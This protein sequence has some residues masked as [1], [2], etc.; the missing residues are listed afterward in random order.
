MVGKATPIML[1]LDDLH[2]ADTPTVSLLRHLVRRAE[3]MRVLV[4]ATYRDSEVTVGHPLHDLL[5]LPLLPA[6]ER[7]T[8][9]GLGDRELVAMLEQ[10]AGHAMDETG[11]G[12]ADALRRDTGGNPFF[13]AELLR[14]LVETGVLYRDDTDRWQLRGTI[15]T[16]GLPDSAREVIGHRVAHL[17]AGTQPVL[18][19]AA[20]IGQEFELTVLARVVDQDDDQVLDHL[21]RSE[22][23]ALVR[24]L[25]GDEFN[26]R[27][28]LVQHALYQD[29]GSARRSR[30]HLRV[31]EAL[32]ALGLADQRPEASAHHLAASGRPE[33]LVKAIGYSRRA[34]DAALAA[35]APDQAAQ[36]YREALRLIDE[37]EGPDDQRCAVLVGFGTALRQTGDG[38]HR[39]VLLDAARL[40]ERL[41]DSD[42]LVQAALANSRGWA[43]QSGHVDEERVAVLEAALTA[44][45]S[46]DT[47]ARARLLAVLASELTFSVDLDRR[48]ALSDEAVAIARRL[49]DLDT[50]TSVLSSR[51]DSVRAP[52]LLAERL[53]AAAEN[54][55]VARML[56]DP[57]ALW[58]ATTGQ[59]QMAVETGDIDAFD[60]SLEQE[61]Q[62]A[63]ELRQ[64]YPRWLTLVHRT[65]RAFVAGQLDE[66]DRLGT[67]A[68]QLGQDI[69]QPDA[70]AIHAANLFS[71]W[72]AQGRVS[73]LLPI[74]EE[75][76]AAN[77]GIP[78]LRAAF[79]SACCEA[80]RLADA[81]AILTEARE[82]GFAAI[83][84][85]GVWLS[86]MFIFAA[87][88]AEVEDRDAAQQ[89][90][91]LLEPFGT[92]FASDGAHIQG[93]VAQVLGRL[94]AVL[95]RDDE[96]DHWFG[97]AEEL[98]GNARATLMQAQTRSY[99][100]AALARRARGTDRA[101]A[102]VLAERARQVGLDLGSPPVVARSD[103]VLAAG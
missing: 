98:E 72:A 13:V 74:L 82:A 88:A 36:H 92:H 7:I 44:I 26:F 93:T 19:A 37:T 38:S 34:G 2:W 18:S 70:F 58:L 102:R 24:N 62:L 4:A 31:A 71:V 35:F 16:L 50:L 6:V 89:L 33:A 22:R 40:A 95:D 5:A 54:M 75:A 87:V 53:S 25:S 61:V 11:V 101:R 32:E 80:N 21:E 17:G 39:E 45:G 3:P 81:Q 103:R 12:L 65:V 41:G 48:R 55:S 86:T 83:K 77:P 78:G 29:L 23:A 63:D 68:F 69:A 90:F 28:A 66:V 47:A 30:L 46:T 79:A 1:V 73:D 51:F 96:S 8:L 99:W 27:H 94:A 85:D 43:S 59:T 57:M 64:P 42:R 67:E 84:L 14:H 15:A 60:E 52:H 10:T 56:D 91:D 76:S 49:G 20:V 97:L 9:T 100:A